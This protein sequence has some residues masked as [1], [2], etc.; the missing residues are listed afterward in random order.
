MKFKLAFKNFPAFVNTYVSTYLLIEK[1]TIKMDLKKSNV[2]PPFEGEISYYTDLRVGKVQMKKK[3]RKKRK[4]FNIIK[5]CRI[6]HFKY[7]C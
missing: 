5:E 7:I 1:I 4:R 6:S 2:H 3:N